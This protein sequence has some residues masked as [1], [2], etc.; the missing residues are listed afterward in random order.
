MNI[1]E[2]GN[3]MP[4]LLDEVKVQL[5]WLVR[6]QF[7]DGSVPVKMGN[8]DY[9]GVWPIHKDERPRYYGP[10]DSGAA[11]YTSANFA[12]AS[13]VY[14]QF[15]AWKPYAEEMKS[16]AVLSWNWFQSNPRTLDKDTGEIKSGIANRSADEQDA[17]EAAAG[18][19]LYFLT[20][21]EKY[22]QA[23]KSKVGKLRQMSEGTWSP[24]GAGMAEVLTE[25]LTMPGRDAALASRIKEQLKKS[26]EDL[27]WNPLPDED[28]YRAFMVPGSYHW[29]SS[30]VR[31]SFGFVALL[32][33]KHG[34]LD[35]A[36]TA[37]LRNRAADMLHSFHGVNPLSMVYLSNMKGAELSASSIYHER[38][39]TGSPFEFNPPPGY[40]VGGANQNFTGKADEG[41][42]SVEWIKTQPRGK[43]YA[44]FNKAWPESS[45]E[46]SEPALGYQCAYIRLLAEF[47]G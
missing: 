29:G 33:A 12:H 20:K 23:F 6:M 25:Y 32:A 10:K 39:R 42:P 16:R 14:S 35:A 44:D 28:L 41:K 34:G 47:A 2:S 13:R 36:M 19:H 37:R 46:L 7:P 9:N 5:D 38:Y 17:M 21:D 15:T 27:A 43:A 3:G 4:D 45:W 30:S 24:Y 18:L 8:I 1:P 11:I 40:V 31:A 26:A 22:H